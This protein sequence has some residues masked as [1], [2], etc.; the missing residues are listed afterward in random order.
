[1]SE[2]TPEIGE[3]LLAEILASAKTGDKYAIRA[4][5]LLGEC[6]TLQARIEALKEAAR[7]VVEQCADTEAVMR[8]RAILAA[9]EKPCAKP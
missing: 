2:M 1:M 9:K 3:A 8:L 4:L 6:K 5:L 7:E